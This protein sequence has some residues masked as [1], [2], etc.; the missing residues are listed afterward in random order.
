METKNVIIKCPNCLQPFSPTEAIWNELKNSIEAELNAEIAIQRSELEREKANIQKLTFKLNAEQAELEELVNSK[1]KIK[2]SVL[3]KQL[4]E[5]INSEKIE[6]LK[7]LEETILKKTEQ[8][9]DHNKV[10]RQL[11]LLQEQAEEKETEIILRYEQKMKDAVDTLRNKSN[12]S[13]QLELGQ[14]NK[15]ISDLEKMLEDASKKVHQYSG[16]LIGESAELQIEQMLKETFPNDSIQEVPKGIRGADVVQE[17]RT[18]TG[19]SIDAKILYEV[20]NVQ[21]YSSGWIEKLKADSTQIP[22]VRAMVIITR[23]LPKEMEG[24]KFGII[25]D[26]FITTHSCAK[27][28]SILL[29]YS[30]LKIN[31]IMLT[32]KGKETTEQ[33]LFEFITSP[34]FKS[35]YERVLSQLDSL[36]ASHEAEKKKLVQLWSDRAKALDIAINSATELFA[37]LCQITDEAPNTDSTKIDLPKAG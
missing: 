24:Q 13:H 32:Y 5:Q 20:K 31:Q 35:I 37:S 36:R 10:K 1:L 21:N 18:M 11:M 26:V 29:R 23:V 16:Q 6:E 28:L 8:L 17:I 30:I 12:E 3:R 15:I 2:E 4:E 7:L 19:A 27:E 22:G 14:K 33:L 25:D 34:G 9:A